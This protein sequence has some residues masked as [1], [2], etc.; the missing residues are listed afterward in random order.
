MRLFTRVLF[1]ATPILHPLSL[2]QQSGLLLAYQPN[3]SDMSGTSRGLYLDTGRLILDGTAREPLNA[4]HDMV[5][6]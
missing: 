4:Y 6:T 1:N 3:P 5:R 2:T